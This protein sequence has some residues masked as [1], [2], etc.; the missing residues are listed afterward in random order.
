MGMCVILIGILYK[1]VDWVA[2]LINLLLLKQSKCKLDPSICVSQT[3]MR[4]EFKWPGLLSSILTESWNLQR[5]NFC[6]NKK[7]LCTWKG[8]YLT[9]FTGDPYSIKGLSW[10][11]YITLGNG[12]KRVIIGC[13]ASWCLLVFWGLKYKDV[14]HC[15]SWLSVCST[16]GHTQTLTAYQICRFSNDEAFHCFSPH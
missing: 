4:R 5:D 6:V 15:V 16:Q 11:R 2:V 12:L 3:I 14:N 10:W 9:G 7:K 13:V 1:W 8:K